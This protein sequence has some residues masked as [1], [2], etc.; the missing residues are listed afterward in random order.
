MVVP[1]TMFKVYDPPSSET[2]VS[3]LFLNFPVVNMTWEAV[4]IQFLIRKLIFMII[5]IAREGSISLQEIKGLVHPKVLTLISLQTSKISVMHACVQR[6][7]T[8]SGSAL[9]PPRTCVTHCRERTSTRERVETKMWNKI[10][11]LFSLRKKYFC[12]FVNLQ[13]NLWCYMEYFTDRL[14][15]FLDMGTF[16]LCCCLWEGLKAL[17][18]NQKHLNFCSDDEQRSYWFGTTSRWVL[19][20]NFNFWV[21]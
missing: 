9:A 8:G 3:K 14:A 6:H 19:N 1:S 7:H 12:G 10:F 18:F 15:T 20:D 5:P 13:L 2:Q 16:Q 4:R 17:R 11:F 21:N